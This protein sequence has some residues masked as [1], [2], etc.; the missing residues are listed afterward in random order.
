MKYDQTAGRQACRA[1][2]D[3]CVGLW[4]QLEDDHFAS[5]IGWF[6]S[7]LLRGLNLESIIQIQTHMF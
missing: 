4:E 3:V 7:F 1:D 2:K 5:G 6:V